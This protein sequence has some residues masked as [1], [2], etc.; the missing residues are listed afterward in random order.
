M[1][2]SE[3]RLAFWDYV[4]DPHQSL[5]DETVATR[6]INRGVEEVGR[7]I[8][9]GDSSYLA[10]CT[11]YRVTS[12]PE[13]ELMF[14][15]PGSFKRAI[16]AERLVSGGRPIP[17]NWVSF[18]RRHQD[19]TWPEVTINNYEAP[20]CSLMGK[21]L[22]VVA[23]SQEYTLRLWYSAAIEELVDSSDVPE[24]IPEDFHELIA[25]EAAKRATAIAERDFG[26]E[27]TY[28]RQLASLVVMTQPRQK[29]RPRYVAYEG[30]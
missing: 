18:Q 17:V 30:Y 3:L 28:Q 9:D 24:L 2:L 23:P 27:D 5:W 10:Q 7:T 12:Y 6:L 19:G 15:L 16:L 21:R 14:D 11:E 22:I 26:H 1:N 29:Q 13:S 25:L 4:D 8:E 20:I